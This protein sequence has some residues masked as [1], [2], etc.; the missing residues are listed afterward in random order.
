MP[1]PIL[2]QGP[3]I[4]DSSAVIAWIEDEPGAAVVT[5][6]IE[7]H[8]GRLHMHGVNVCET[9]Y[10]FGKVEKAES[11]DADTRAAISRA[12]TETR[13]TLDSVGIVEHAETDRALM[14]F[15]AVLKADI[16]KVSLADCCLMAL[17]ARLGGTVITADRKE[18]DQPKPLA[19]CSI[20]FIR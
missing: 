16:A 19:A 11:G 13:A 20:R 7:D 1:D 5:Q 10:H 2:L 6:V 18:L 9:L 3:V 4:L 17:A 8:Y 15:A 12:I 14:D